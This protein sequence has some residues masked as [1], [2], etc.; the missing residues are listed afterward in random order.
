MNG[1]GAVTGQTCQKWFLKFHAR[2]FSLDNISWSGK[3]VEVDSNQ[4][5]N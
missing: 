5:I 2:D 4:I 1:E 3:P